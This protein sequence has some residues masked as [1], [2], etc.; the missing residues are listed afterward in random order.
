VH[1]VGPALDDPRR[2]PNQL[3]TGRVRLQVRLRLAVRAAVPSDDGDGR[4]PARARRRLDHDLDRHG[5]PQGRSAR[6][7]GQSD[8]R[9]PL[10]GTADSRPADGG[11]QS[12]GHRGPG[13]RG[14]PRALWRQPVGPRPDDAA[15]GDD[16]S[17]SEAQVR[18]DLDRP[19][20]H[21]DQGHD[22]QLRIDGQARERSRQRARLRCGRHRGTGRRRAEWSRSPSSHSAS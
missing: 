16:S 9:R 1:R 4:D 17:G 19:Q 21:P 22:G 12:R 15:L 13:A 5:V 7:A 8:L 11:A 10:P 18:R 3:P 2:D 6:E 14:L 20:G